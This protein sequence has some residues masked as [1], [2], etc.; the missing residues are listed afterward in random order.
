MKELGWKK[1]GNDSNTPD[2]PYMGEEGLK[3]TKWV[4]YDLSTFNPT[5]EGT[6]G[7]GELIYAQD[8][9]AT[10]QS[11]PNFDKARGFQDDRLQIFHPTFKSRMLVDCALGELEDVGLK[12]EVI[13]FRHW[14]NERDKKHQRHIEL[15]AEIL[16]AEQ[17]Y[18]ASAH[19]LVQ[20]RTASRVGNQMFTHTIQMPAPL[21]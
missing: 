2:V 11:H 19:Y 7:P 10:P 3:R 17:V 18:H 16:H 8:L 6:N 20:A 13:R 4:H 21:S 15:E 12:A 14:A 9:H 5:V 1:Y